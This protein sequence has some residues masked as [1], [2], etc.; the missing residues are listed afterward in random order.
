MA[1]TFQR[2]TQNSPA[3]HKEDP[4]L[5]NTA[6]DAKG[7]QGHKP[8]PWSWPPPTGP[9]AQSTHIPLDHHS[10]GCQ[11]EPQENPGEL[12]AVSALTEGRKLGLFPGSKLLAIQILS[13]IKRETENVSISV[14]LPPSNSR[15]KSAS[16]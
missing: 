8:F 4:A 13:D 11:T 7:Q 6:D 1:S 14:F 2:I 5:K 3:Q 16:V 10:G 12:G 9:A 15:S